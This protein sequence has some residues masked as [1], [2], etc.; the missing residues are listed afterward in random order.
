MT[1]FLSLDVTVCDVKQL[2]FLLRLSDFLVPRQKTTVTGSSSK[3][4]ES[5]NGKNRLDL[6]LLSLFPP[7]NLL[8]CFGLIFSSLF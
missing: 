8:A 5:L 4:S 6:A 3:F 7:S 2:N 1:R